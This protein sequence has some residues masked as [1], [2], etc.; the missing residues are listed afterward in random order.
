[1][2]VE[3]FIFFLTTWL[4]ERWVWPI[5][6]PLNP[7]SPIERELRDPVPWWKRWLLKPAFLRGT[8]NRSFTDK[9]KP[10]NP[11]QIDWWNVCPSGG[12]AVIDSGSPYVNS[13][14]IPPS[15]SSP[16]LYQ[17]RNKVVILESPI[18]RRIKRADTGTIES[19]TAPYFVCTFIAVSC[20]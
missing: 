16:K 5:R 12:S 2:V 13:A 3:L 15:T 1:M 9:S 17:S 8:D 11:A 7:P 18:S 19:K 4:V 14:H 6:K 20:T 10:W